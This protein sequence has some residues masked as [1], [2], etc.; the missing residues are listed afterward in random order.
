IDLDGLSDLG[1]DADDDSRNGATANLALIDRGGTA[2]LDWRRAGLGRG[3]ARLAGG[4]S[5]AAL[6]RLRLRHLDLDFVNLAVNGD[7]EFQGLLLNLSSRQAANLSAIAEPASWQLAGTIRYAGIERRA[8]RCLD[9]DTALLGP[10]RGAKQTDLPDVGF[11]A[12]ERRDGCADD[13]D[14]FLGKAY[15]FRPHPP[16]PRGGEEKS[17]LLTPHAFVDGGERMHSGC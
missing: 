11:L 5:I 9:G 3:N 1:R 10:G 2:G 13:H 4:W 16:L 15:D 7:L 12:E 8:V 14:N 6:R 17:R